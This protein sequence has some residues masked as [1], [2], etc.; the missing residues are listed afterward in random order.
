MSQAHKELF[1]RCMK[2]TNFSI[3]TFFLIKT[4]DLPKH[5]EKERSKSSEKKAGRESEREAREIV[6]ICTYQPS[7]GYENNTVVPAGDL[8]RYSV[9]DGHTIFP[10]K[11]GVA[12]AVRGVADIVRYIVTETGF[13]VLSL[14]THY[15]LRVQAYLWYHI[16]T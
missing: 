7:N 2:F 6:D 13:K 3:I 16:A 5:R 1:L 15:H 9:R 8:L 12:K 14:I 4:A 11:H 10:D